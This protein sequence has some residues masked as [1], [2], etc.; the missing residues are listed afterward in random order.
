MNKI[1]IGISERIKTKDAV[2]LII[3]TF[4]DLSSE[5]K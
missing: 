1:N 2:V 4:S 3:F 5:L